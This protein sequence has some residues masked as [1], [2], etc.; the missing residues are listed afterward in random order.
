[1]K[2]YLRDSLVEL[3][4]T[5]I[6]LAKVTNVTP[7]VPLT[8]EL[9]NYITASE[10]LAANYDREAIRVHS[11][12]AGYR[13]K[14]QAIGQSVKKNPPTAEAL[15]KNIQ[16]RGSMPRVNSIVDLYN[17]EALHSFLAIGAH[18]FDTITEFVEFTRAYEATVF[19]P[20]GSNE[21]QVSVGDIIYRD[22]KGV[23][24]YL[25]A[26]DGE[27]YKIT[28]KTKNLLL[29]MQG[30]ANTDVPSR[31]AAL[32]RVCK[33]IK[34]ICPLSAYEIAVVTQKDDTFFE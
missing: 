31:I 9:E 2:F 6:V 13:A 32:K 21:K 5:A 34:K 7:D 33:N 22:Q 8:K 20:I 27:A 18:D 15:I 24:A 11:V 16:R 29:I 30:N 1:M 4:M 17:A 26:R 12:I 14:M 10:K 19:F 28:P 25:D 23:M 3:G